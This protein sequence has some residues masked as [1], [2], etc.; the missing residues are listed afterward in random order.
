[1][2]HY[3]FLLFVWLT[4]LPVSAQGSR[5]YVL[6]YN[7]SDY[8]L[9]TDENGLSAIRFGKQAYHTKCNAN[10]PNLPYKMVR[11]LLPYQQDVERVEVQK[12]D[13]LLAEGITLEAAKAIVPGNIQPDSIPVYHYN[14]EKTYDAYV[15]CVDVRQFRPYRLA[16]LLVSP[17]T[18]DALHKRLYVSTEINVILHFKKNPVQEQPH[19]LTLDECKAYCQQHALNGSEMETLYASLPTKRASA[20]PSPNAV[21][22]MIITSEA[23][24]EAFQPLATWKTQKGCRAKIVT[25]EEI[26]QTEGLFKPEDQTLAAKIKRYLQQF[27]AAGELKYILLGGDDVIVP[28]YSHKFDEFE[29]VDNKFKTFEAITDL[30]Y[31]C[32]GD[33]YGYTWGNQVGRFDLTPSY[34]VGRASVRTIKHVETFVNKI[35]TY[36]QKGIQLPVQLD[37]LKPNTLSLIGASLH[38]NND[39]KQYCENLFKSL[40]QNTSMTKGNAIYDLQNLDPYKYDSIEYIPIKQK[41][42]HAILCGKQQHVFIQSHG[43]Y[44]LFVNKMGPFFDGDPVDSFYT[45]ELASKLVSFFPKIITTSACF[46]NGFSFREKINTDHEGYYD[47]CISEAFMRNP[48]SGIIAFIGSTREGHGLFHYDPDAVGGPSNVLIRDFYV[49]L[50]QPENERCLG[51]AHTLACCY[52]EYQPH[53][54][55]CSLSTCLLGDPEMRVYSEKPAKIVN[56]IYEHALNSSWVTLS[57]DGRHTITLSNEGTI[58]DKKD[59]SSYLNFNMDDVPTEYVTACF[60]NLNALPVRMDVYKDYYFRK[61]TMTGEQ[62]YKG[63]NFYFANWWNGTGDDITL[64]SGSTTTLKGI[65]KLQIG[66]GFKSEKG[67]ALK[68]SFFQ[69]KPY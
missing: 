48:K 56:A 22:Y 59:N 28:T 67:A 64:Q 36:E 31:A 4:V 34:Y 7:L 26:A 58:Y 5:S 50:A 19:V 49:N 6:N 61:M 65:G 37:S 20:K 25:V 39:G 51:K 52:G 55:F 47:P 8:E 42:V 57:V 63:N 30:Y 43:D 3:L 33:K 12:V 44:H 53:A 14:M 54:L 15:Q 45:K 62:T 10:V 27:V 13:A 60:S 16:N 32:Y 68:V 69:N 24:K 66:R 1:M 18:Y 35:L 38:N 41:D 40:Q 2:K 23:L 11:I 21:Q 46:T 29:G 9:A 17:F